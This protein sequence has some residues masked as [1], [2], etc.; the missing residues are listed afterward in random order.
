VKDPQMNGSDHLQSLICST[1]SGCYS[2]PQIFELAAVS[3]HLLSY[4]F[5]TI[6]QSGVKYE[7]VLNY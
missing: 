4:R 5:I 6:L 1:N 2:Q 3:E 7:H